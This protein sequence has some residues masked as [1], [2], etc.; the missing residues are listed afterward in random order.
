MPTQLKEL[1]QKKFFP[2]SGEAFRFFPTLA[3][4]VP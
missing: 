3:A 1:R 4:G 2:G